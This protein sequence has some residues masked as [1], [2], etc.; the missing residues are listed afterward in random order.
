MLPGIFTRCHPINAVVY[1]SQ[2]PM[3][4]LFAAVLP[5]S[6]VLPAW[7]VCWTITILTPAV[8]V[9]PKEVMNVE[10][11]PGRNVLQVMFVI[12]HSTALAAQANAPKRLNVAGLIK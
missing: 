10:A 6:S 8:V 1:V 7:S 12:L 9:Y 2:T 4:A 5:A 11:I 3:A